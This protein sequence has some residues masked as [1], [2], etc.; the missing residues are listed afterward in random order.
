MNRQWRRE[1]EGG[2]RL[3][4]KKK[5]MV[6]PAAPNIAIDNCNWSHWRASRVSHTASLHINWHRPKGAAGT[7][8]K[9][10]AA[11]DFCRRFPRLPA[12]GFKQFKVSTSFLDIF[13]QVVNQSDATWFKWTKSSFIVNMNV[14]A[15]FEYFFLTIP[16][17]WFVRYK[18]GT[19]ASLLLFLS[20]SKSN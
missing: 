18:T 17:I 19:P 6:G 8:T 11:D 4:E 1:W 16:A 7:W 12:L 5:N 9:T 2:G 15:K 3:N 20:V 13:L 10:H 14:G